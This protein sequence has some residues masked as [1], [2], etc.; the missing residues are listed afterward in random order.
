VAQQYRRWSTF[1]LLASPLKKPSMQSKGSPCS[2]DLPTD[3]LAMRSTI[4]SITMLRTPNNNK[5][6]MAM[7]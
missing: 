7:M 3:C 5:Q 4:A 1:Q 2:S 6:G